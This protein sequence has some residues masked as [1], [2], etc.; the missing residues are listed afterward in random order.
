MRSALKTECVEYY[1]D[2]KTRYAP[3]TCTSS[4]PKCPVAYSLDASKKVCVST[5]PTETECAS[6][7]TSV[8]TLDAGN[9][10]AKRGQCPSGGWKLHPKSAEHC[11]RA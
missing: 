9:K 3:A 8:T 10:C 5:L 1:Q 11:I 6:P 4:V 7:Y 2:K